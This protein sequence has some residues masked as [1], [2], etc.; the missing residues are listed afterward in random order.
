MASKETK[1][2]HMEWKTSNGQTGEGKGLIFHEEATAIGIKV[3]IR[4]TENRFLNWQ[5]FRR[6]ITP[7]LV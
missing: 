1:W 7:T 2:L 3:S 6:R 4:V 5:Y